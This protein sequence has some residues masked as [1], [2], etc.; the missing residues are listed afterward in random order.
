MHSEAE[1]QELRDTASS[2]LMAM[3]QANDL[4]SHT[5]ELMNT[6]NMSFKS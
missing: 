2:S 5:A 1:S 6:Y 3:G 4:V